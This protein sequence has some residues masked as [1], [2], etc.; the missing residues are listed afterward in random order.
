MMNP[1]VIPKL[2]ED[3]NGD[4]RKLSMVRVFKKLILN[5]FIIEKCFFIIVVVC[6]Y[7]IYCFLTF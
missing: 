3:N 5:D 6:F 7:S 1:C 4:E 2:S